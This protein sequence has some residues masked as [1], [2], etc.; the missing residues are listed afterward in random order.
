V[1]ALQDQQHHVVEMQRLCAE[2][3]VELTRVEPMRPG[4]FDM[5]DLECLVLRFAGDDDLKLLRDATCLSREV[6][7]GCNWD[8]SGPNAL[9]WRRPYRRAIPYGDLPELV[10][11][12][13]EA[14][15]REAADANWRDEFLPY[16][17]EFAQAVYNRWGA[18]GLKVVQYGMSTI[19]ILGA[20][21]LLL[22][23]VTSTRSWPSYTWGM[24]A[25]FGWSWC[26]LRFE[27][28]A[29]Y[30]RDEVSV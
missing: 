30:V 28:G 19:S 10:W 26:S 1:S 16:A 20:L 11:C 25:L 12:L 2:L 23:A 22:W 14:I 29:R 7:F 8:R 9:H 18:S 4:E 24:A 17:S 3:D 13:R 5:G 6:E 27:R 15:R 21:L